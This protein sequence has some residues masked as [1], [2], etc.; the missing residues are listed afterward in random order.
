MSGIFS[1]SIVEKSSLSQENFS[2]NLEKG[3]EMITSLV[4]G[5]FALLMLGFVNSLALIVLL[6][7]KL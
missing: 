3:K 5:C 1:V 6:W 7:V 4:I 2:V